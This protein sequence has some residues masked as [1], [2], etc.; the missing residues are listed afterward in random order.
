M[1]PVPVN[2]GENCGRVVNLVIGARLFIVPEVIESPT[3]RLVKLN[4]GS[5]HV[6]FRR[7][8]VAAG[9]LNIQRHFRPGVSRRCRLPYIPDGQ[10]HV[11]E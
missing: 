3:A 9:I 4:S 10:N 8:Q 7:G 11:D 5:I 1:L 2:T 6:N